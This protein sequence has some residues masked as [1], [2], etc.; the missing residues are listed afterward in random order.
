MKISVARPGLA[1]VEAVLDQGG[2]LPPGSLV[3]F[4]M[5][6][7]PMSGHILEKLQAFAA[8]TCSTRGASVIRSI[9]LSTGRTCDGR[10]WRIT[11]T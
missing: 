2:A 5:V 10:D 9:C 1:L 7:D 8:P 11:S 4:P 3:G 6:T